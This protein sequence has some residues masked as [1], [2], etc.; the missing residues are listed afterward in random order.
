MMTAP[1]PRLFEAEAMRDD[2]LGAAERASFELHTTV[3]PTCAREVATLDALANALDASH[4]EHPNK[5]HVRRQR[6]RL[7]AAFNGEL[8]APERLQVAPRRLLWSAAIGA[9]A[10]AALVVWRVHRDGDHAHPIEASRAVIR[11][12]DAAAWSER[13]R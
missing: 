10:T 5:L 1:C 6:T 9:L 8:L 13:L 11:A 2:R 3:C 12:D 4:S 7:L